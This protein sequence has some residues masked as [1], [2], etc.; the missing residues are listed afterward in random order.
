GGRYAY[1]SDANLLR[2]WVMD[3]TLAPVI[4]AYLGGFGHGRLLTENE[5]C[6]YGLTS[7]RFGQYIYVLEEGLAFEPSTFAR[8][9]PVGMHGYHPLVPSQQALL[10]HYGPAWNGERPERMGDVYEMLRRA[11]GGTWS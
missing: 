3:P 4:E 7:R 9:K 2:V 8:H 6:T 11:L 5:R 10:A 1:F